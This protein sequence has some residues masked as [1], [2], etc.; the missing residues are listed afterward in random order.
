[1][2]ST[3]RELRRSGLFR[4]ARR[5]I[6]RGLLGLIGLVLLAVPVALTVEAVRL[7]RDA[8]EFPPRGKRIDLGGRTLHLDCRGE[9]SPTVVIESGAQDWS[10]GWQ[11]PQDAIAEHTRVC[12]YDRAGLGWSDAS[13]EPHDGLHMVADL[14][15]LL[16]AAGLSTPVVLVGHSLGG[17]LNRIHFQQYPEEVAGMVLIEPG[18]PDQIDEMFGESRGAPAYGDWVD[19][20]ASSAARLGMTR[21]VFRNL[22]S[23]KGFPEREVAETRAMISRPAAVRAL[24]STL[25]HLPVTSAQTRASGDLGDLPL[26]VVYTSKFDE[27]GTHFESEAEREEFLVRSVEYWEGLVELSSRGRGPIVIEGANHLT[28]IRDDR[29]WPQAVEVILEVVE[30]VHSSS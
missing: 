24:A 3:A 9:G 7:S 14:H 6:G 19:V 22:F 17:M 29:F 16:A 11:R 2:T 13:D 18:D 26:A 4:A 10:T 8:R 27:Y 5:W 28:V 20:L 1:M 23:G 15:R 12:T 21:W 30:E 25:R